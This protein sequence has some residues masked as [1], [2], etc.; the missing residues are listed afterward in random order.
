MESKRAYASRSSDTG[1]DEKSSTD[2][3]L[4]ARASSESTSVSTGFAALP[5]WLVSLMFS[6]L[7]AG[8]AATAAVRVSA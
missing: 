5:L 6:L 8:H 3:T 1:S 4:A 7:G 2:V